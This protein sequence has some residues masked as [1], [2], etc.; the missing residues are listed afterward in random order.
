MDYNKKELK[1]FRLTNKNGMLV[2]ILNLGGIII[3]IMVPDKDGI[4]ENVVLAY[5]NIEDY[6]YNPSSFGCIVGR[7]AGR[8]GNANVCIEGVKYNF[9]KNNNGNCLH[10]GNEG[11][12]KKFWRGSVEKNKDNSKVILTYKSNDGEEGYPGNL[13]ITVIYEL[14]NNNELS[15]IYKG[16]TDKDTIVNLTNH[17]YFNLS[18]NNKNNI[19][20]EEL[21]VNSNK[22]CELDEDLIPTGNFIK[23]KDTP[24]DFT[25]FKNIGKDIEDN[26][27]QLKYGNGYDHPW[28]LNK[29]EK[30]AAT[31]YDP[32]SARCMDVITNQ[33][34]L[35]IYSMNFPDKLIL[36]N[37]KVANKRQ[38]ICFEA[39][40]LPIGYNDCFI[41][42]TILKVEEEY[43]NKTIFKFY[44][45]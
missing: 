39:Q 5:K 35:V 17:S 26:N 44:T 21:L 31:L 32:V 8:I 3:K 14:N 42:D 45:K 40:G 28:V 43:N 16:I 34:A 36:E 37:N 18:G 10:G 38:A 13:D 15:I 41:E 12:S 23:V 19:L 30:V 6:F 2:E 7:T 11:F 25:S 20:N 4:L 9:A 33:K 24:F 22:I 29:N 27:I 1:I